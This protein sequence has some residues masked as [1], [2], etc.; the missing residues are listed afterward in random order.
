MARSRRV[1]LAVLFVA[2]GGLCWWSLRRASTHDCPV[3]TA[4]IEER[5]SVVWRLSISSE[6]D[7]EISTSLSLVVSIILGAI[8]VRSGLAQGSAPVKV[9]G[10]DRHSTRGLLYSLRWICAA[11]ELE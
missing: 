3:A 7:D 4:L 1:V 6:N 2:E 5:V 8:D 10:E 9:F 11:R